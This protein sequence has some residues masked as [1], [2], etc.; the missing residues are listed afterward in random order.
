MSVS[1]EG[2]R[3]KDDMYTATI[4]TEVASINSSDGMDGWTDGWTDGQ[5]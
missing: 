1:A 3:E 4:A 2:S 5:S